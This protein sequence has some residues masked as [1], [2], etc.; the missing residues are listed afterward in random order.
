MFST[1]AEGE[2][3]DVDVHGPGRLQDPRLL[4][5]QLQRAQHQQPAQP[6]RGQAHQHYVSLRA[7]PR[8]EAHLAG[9]PHAHARSTRDQR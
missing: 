5:V 6:H 7:L 9:V 4:G 3:D 1:V 8:T 2:G